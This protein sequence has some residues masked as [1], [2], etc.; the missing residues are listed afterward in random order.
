MSFNRSLNLE[1]NPSVT[2]VNVF[3]YEENNNVQYTNFDIG[4]DI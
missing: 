1:S 4:Y 3:C 2:E